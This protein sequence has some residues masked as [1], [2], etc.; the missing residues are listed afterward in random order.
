ML[1]SRLVP[2]VCALSLAAA[3]LLQPGAAPVDPT[4]F[5]SAPTPSAPTSQVSLLPEPPADSKLVIGAGSNLRSVVEQLGESTGVLFRA[6]GETWSLLN[7]L[8][9]GLDRPAEIH[10]KDAWRFLNDLL[11]S[12]Q[13]Y[14]GALRMNEPYLLEILPSR[15]EGRQRIARSFPLSLT[16]DQLEAFSDYTALMVQVAFDVQ[17]V[18]ANHVAHSMRG[19][20]TDDNVSNVMAMG[21]SA[22]LASGPLRVVDAIE[23]GVKAADEAERARWELQQK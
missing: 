9:C 1:R 13:L 6:E 5:A 16:A 19:L 22:V 23:A 17:H 10:G 20:S 2:V 8:Y 21:S 15:T 7:D 18:D 4:A 3:P 14:I 11:L 12:N